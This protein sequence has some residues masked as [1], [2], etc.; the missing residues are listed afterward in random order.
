MQR[1]LKRGLIYNPKGSSLFIK[2]K[3]F[4][5][6]DLKNKHIIIIVDL[7]TKSV[8]QYISYMYSYVHVHGNLFC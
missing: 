7:I 5:F 6:F 3:A 2:L 1:R 8:R 4:Q